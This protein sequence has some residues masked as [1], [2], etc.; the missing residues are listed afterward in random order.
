MGMIFLLK[1][2][3]ALFIVCQFTLVKSMI[4]TCKQFS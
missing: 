2:S 1:G 3:D 4:K